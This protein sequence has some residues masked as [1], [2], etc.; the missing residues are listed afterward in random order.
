MPLDPKPSNPLNPQN[1]PPREFWWGFDVG[2]RRTRVF[3]WGTQHEIAD[4]CVNFDNHLLAIQT[5]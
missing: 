2:R 3:I 4:F 1:Q 5:C